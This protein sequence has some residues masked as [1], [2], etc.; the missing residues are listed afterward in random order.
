M[1][2]TR[3][4]RGPKHVPSRTCRGCPALLATG[5]MAADITVLSGGAIEPGL[6]G[7]VAAFEKQTGHRV[8]VTFNTTPQIQKRIESRR[9]VRRRDRAARGDRRVRQGGTRRDRRPERRPRRAGRGRATRCPGSRPRER[10]VA[11]ARGDRGGLDR[12]QSCVHRDLL[13]E[14]SEENGRLE[15][16]SRA[17]P[18]AIR[19]GHP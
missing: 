2:H 17:R 19:M 6:R 7:A 9:Q 16:R 1:K 12:L 3:S 14:P 4:L 15:R 10:R 5:A 11:Q 18:P 13:R 8:T